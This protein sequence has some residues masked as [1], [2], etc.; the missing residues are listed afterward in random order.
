MRSPGRALAHLLAI[1]C[2]LTFLI[3]PASASDL[4]ET[5]AID[6]GT[7]SVAG[8]IL[9]VTPFDPSLGT[10]DRVDVQIDGTAVMT[11]GTL[12][13]LLPCGP[14]IC[15][16]PEPFSIELDAGFNGLA[17]RFFSFSSPAKYIGTGATDGLGTP[18]V[19]T[20]PYTMDFSFTS[21]TDLL[22]LTVPKITGWQVPPI[23]DGKLADFETF[24][25][26]FYELQDSF[27]FSSMALN[28][29]YP[30]SFSNDGTMQITYQYAPPAPPR[31]PEPASL[32]LLGSG[33]LALICTARRRMRD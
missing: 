27:Q 14:A 12:P 15:P 20:L 24:V 6:L 21:A 26:R 2:G 31:V 22:G 5:Q 9:P 32:L 33:A 19:L 10:L 29:A 25:G 30:L 16:T 17:S 1:C 11:V 7:N 8:S 3:M 23:V 13:N 4:S 28:A 18:Q